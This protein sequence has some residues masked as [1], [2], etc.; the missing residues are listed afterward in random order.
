MLKNLVTSSVYQHVHRSVDYGLHSRSS[1]QSDKQLQIRNGHKQGQ[2]GRQCNSLW[3]RIRYSTG[4]THALFRI[5][6]V[7]I[8]RRNC[9]LLLAMGVVVALASRVVF[10]F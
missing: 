1:I 2:P 10:W 6:F 5:C 9:L 7:L 4:I 3:D 8:M